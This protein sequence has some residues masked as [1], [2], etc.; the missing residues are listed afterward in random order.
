MSRPDRSKW[1]GAKTAC[2]D[3]VDKEGKPEPCSHEDSN[4]V[5]MLVKGWGTKHSGSGRC[6]YHGGNTPNG[7]KG[8]EAEAAKTLL[9]DL[10]V[11]VSGNP[12]Q[13]LQ[14]VLDS[15]HGVM[16]AARRMLA[17]LP[18]EADVDEKAWARLKLYRESI[19]AAG[20]MAK[21]AAE[22]V[23]EDA[24]V[25]VDLA[26]GEILHRVLVAALDAYEAAGAGSEGRKAA[27]D[28][29]VR[30]LVAVAPTTDERN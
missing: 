29:L 22:A 25:Q 21:L 11:P 17:E 6:R 9:A 4:H 23:N 12:L 5:C 19:E 18:R 7:R 14:A 16:D 3:R 1:C 26:T 30:E 20:R 15:A 24:L 13:V 10:A 27:E 2:A 28:A 8:A